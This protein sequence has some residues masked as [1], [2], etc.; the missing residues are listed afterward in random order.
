MDSIE[1]KGKT[2]DYIGYLPLILTDEQ[3]DR[4]GVYDKLHPRTWKN[5]SIMCSVMC[6]ENI[7]NNLHVWVDIVSDS[8]RKVCGKWLNEVKSFFK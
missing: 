3:F 7:D 8:H 1:Y 6:I 4:W 5:M 2:L